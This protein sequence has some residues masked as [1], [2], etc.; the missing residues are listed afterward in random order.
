MLS[1]AATPAAPLLGNS[2]PLMRKGTFLP[3]LAA[4]LGQEVAADRFLSRGD[5]VLPFRDL[6]IHL[7]ALLL[8][9]VFGIF[10]IDGFLGSVFAF[11]LAS[12]LLGC[13]L[14]VHGL[15]LHRLLDRQPRT[16]MENCF[17]LRHQRF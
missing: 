11:L 17:P 5:L 16:S 10:A 3:L 6:G 12:F 2:L 1:R 8:L 14:T 15:H 9:S 13:R 7:T 4:R